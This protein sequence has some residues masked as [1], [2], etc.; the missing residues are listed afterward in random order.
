[1][2]NLTPQ[3]VCAIAASSLLSLNASALTLENHT[4]ENLPSLGTFT[5][6]DTFQGARKDVLLG[7]FSGLFFEG[8]ANNDTN[9]PVFVTHPD[10]G[11]NGNT[12]NLLP[13]FPGNE[14]PFPLPQFQPEITRFELNRSTSQITILDRIGLTRPGF[15]GSFVPMT[16]LPNNPAGSPNV[17]YTDEV[18]VDINGNVLNGDAFGADM[19]GIVRMADGGYW[20]SDEYRPA[21]YHF[22]AKGQMINRF[23]PKGM[24]A[25]TAEPVGTFGIEL[26]PEVYGQRRRNRGFEALA[27]NEDTDKLYA[28]IQSPIDNPEADPGSPS[29]ANAR[30]SDV[31][32]ILEMDIADPDAPTV[33]GEFV[34]MLE[35]RGGADLFPDNNVDKIGDAVWLGDGRFA[36]I[37]RDSGVGAGADK[38]VFEIDLAGATN[39]LGQTY[40]KE[41]EAFVDAA[42]LNLEGIVPVAKTM[43]F[44]LPS[45]GYL[46]GDKPEGLALL[47]NI[48]GSGGIGL[49]IIND[50]D[51]GLADVD[52]PGDGTLP[53]ADSPTPVVVG[54][55]TDIPE[56]ASAVL[57]GLGSVLVIRRRR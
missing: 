25:A 35:N 41:L 10:R 24:E 57:L 28:F 20:M 1:M 50:N 23:V 21:V 13:E 55:V 17:A 45:I 56:P 48:D 4:F 19:E 15:A 33:T 49:A 12:Q 47:P 30:V 26:L 16:G 37:Q 34:Y 36:V 27:L 54:I 40:S 29:D 5:P 42:E 7:G 44:D 32:R 38:P 9:R 52:F 43:L 6:T 11:P 2:K 46:A 31:I 51:F 53:F 8:Y 39:V 3:G 22:N 18:P 14:R